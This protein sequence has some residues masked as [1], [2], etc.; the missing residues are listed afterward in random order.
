MSSPPNPIHRRT[1][2]VFVLGSPR[3]GTTLL[4]DMLLSAGGFAV[5]LA[6]SN[7]F[8]VLAPNFGDLRVRRNRRRLLDA[9]L[10]SKLFRA[11]GLQRHEV[12]QQVLEHCHGAGDFLRVVMDG[13]AR[14]QGMQRWA[15]NSPEGILHLPRIKTHIPE[16]LVIHIIRD[17]RDVAMSLNRTR[18]LHPIPWQ[19]RIS[20]VGAAVYWEWIVG[21]GRHYGRQLGSDYMEVHFEDLVSAP[22]ELLKKIGAFIG[23]ELDYDRILEVGYGSVSK[24]NSSFRSESPDTFNPVGRWKK[25]FTE[26][27]LL[28]C[29][30]MV[31][32]TLADL[33]YTLSSNPTHRNVKTEAIKWMY[34]TYFESKLRFKIHPLVRKLH[35]LTAAGID[36]MVLAEDHPPDLRIPRSE[37]VEGA[38]EDPTQV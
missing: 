11:S 4:Y 1:A 26:R 15:E 19:D 33:G 22:R 20:L 28:H 2:P 36:A 25:G 35:P 5:Y 29:E 7:V 38:L 34:R 13:I 6:E 31:G 8:N 27:E 16:A 18:Y 23:Q 14:R 9:W 10:G 32:R 21:R 37:E 3:S 24:P 30:S 12:E 17:G